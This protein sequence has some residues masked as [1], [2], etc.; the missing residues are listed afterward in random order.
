MC[1]NTNKFIKYILIIIIQSVLKPLNLVKHIF[2]KIN[3]PFV[4]YNL[5]IIALK[6]TWCFYD[7]LSV[8]NRDVVEV[9]LTEMVLS[10]DDVAT[11]LASIS[12]LCISNAQIKFHTMIEQ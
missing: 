12:T 3:K 11:V 6:M 4:V 9:V 2:N 1:Q 7:A 8:N 5:S 10:T